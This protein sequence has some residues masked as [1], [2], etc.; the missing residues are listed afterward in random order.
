M[1]AIG[2]AVAAAVGAIVRAHWA[3]L[4]WR[5]TLG[6]N[7][8]GSLLLGVLVGRWETG[9]IVLVL[10]TGFCGALTTFGTFALEASTGPAR[11]R[12][13]VIAANVL[14]C[15]ALASVGYALAT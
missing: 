5:A 7:L 9:D 2:I 14:G 10:G 4:G 3:P 11:L 12:L 15:V 1:T 13:I 8:V 6:V